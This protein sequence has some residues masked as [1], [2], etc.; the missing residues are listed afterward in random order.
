[1]K[2]V[3]P[4]LIS[5][6]FTFVCGDEERTQGTEVFSPEERDAWWST[7]T[8]TEQQKL[9]SIFFSDWLE[10]LD[11]DTRLSYLQLTS[12]LYDFATSGADSDPTD[13]YTGFAPLL[14][15]TSFH[16]S[17]T[18][19]HESGMGGSNGGTIFQQGELDD[20][21]NGCIDKA[22]KALQELFQGHDV[23]LADAVVI[24]GVVA[25]DIMNVSNY[26][27]LAL[28]CSMYI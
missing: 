15:R 23:P 10:E 3:V 20:E 5:F 4:F 21:Q 16:S 24:A 13:Q 12:S 9:E 26:V 17:G 11:D 22:T 14:L 25:L 2:I 7:L 28:G 6:L 18:Y 27:E 1:M 8:G 19:H